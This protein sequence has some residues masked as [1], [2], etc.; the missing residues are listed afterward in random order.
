MKTN[1]SLFPLHSIKRLAVTGVFL[2]FLKTNYAQDNGAIKIVVEDRDTRESIGGAWAG[3]INSEGLYIE[4]NK[5][6]EDGE[7]YLKPLSPG[8]YTVQAH[9]NSRSSVFLINVLVGEGKTSYVTL[10][11]G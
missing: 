5:T 1:Y 2:M 4:S 9:Y 6:N 7:A 8:L 10:P 3:A 11:L